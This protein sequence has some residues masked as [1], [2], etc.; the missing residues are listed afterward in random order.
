MF[1]DVLRLVETAKTTGDFSSFIG[2]KE[3]LWFEAKCGNAYNWEITEDVLEFA[4]DVS[5]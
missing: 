2:L 4:K 5:A 3:D 1:D